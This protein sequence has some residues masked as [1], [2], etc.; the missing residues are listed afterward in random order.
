M[1]FLL[2]TG[3]E[4]QGE[5]HDNNFIVTSSSAFIKFMDGIF[6]LKEISM[7]FQGNKLFYAEIWC[8]FVKHIFE[9]GKKKTKRNRDDFRIENEGDF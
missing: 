7:V 8:F 6:F 4:K 5:I 2:E 1:V 9:I 3:K